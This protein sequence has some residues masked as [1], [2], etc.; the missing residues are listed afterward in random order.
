MPLTPP[1]VLR[2]QNEKFET[3]KRLLTQ[4]PGHGPVTIA[5]GISL[6]EYANYIST[7]PK[8][9]VNICLIGGNIEAY[10]IPYT[11]HS[12]VASIMS[13]FIPPWT[14]P[15]MPPHNL[16]SGSERFIKVGPDNSFSP[17]MSYR[18]A[19]RLPAPGQTNPNFVYPTLV[20]EVS[21]SETFRHVHQKAQLYL[22]HTPVQLVLVIKFWEIRQ[23]NLFG[24]V[25]VLYQTGTPTIAISCGTG[26][27]EQ[28]AARGLDHQLGLNV[29]TGVGY[30]GPNGPYPPCDTFNIPEYRINLPA[31]ALWQGDPQ[32]I[33]AGYVNGID[34][35]LYIIQQA[36]FRAMTETSRA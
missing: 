14:P 5:E 11:P 1:R 19:Q 23:S 17:D 24:M 30:N 2:I 9:P 35:D 18:P 32:G 7:H 8:L 6:D 26:N 27:I 4:N 16:R 34:L 10:E 3:A 15:P 28:M 36:A 21:V 25:V 33:P 22:Q 12:E 13:Y 20:V 31:A 29:I